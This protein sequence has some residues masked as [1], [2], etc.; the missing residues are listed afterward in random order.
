MDITETRGLVI[1]AGEAK[2]CCIHCKKALGSATMGI[3]A[4]PTILESR[5]MSHTILPVFFNILMAGQTEIRFLLH[6]QFLFTGTMSHMTDAAIP[7]LNRGMNMLSR[8]NN[9]GYILM[10]GEAGLTLGLTQNK[11]IIASMGIM[12]G[13]TL[14]LHKGLMTMVLGL[15][16]ANCLMAGQAKL[17]LGG[18]RL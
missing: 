14:A 11:G 9:L 1:V 16:F 7:S 17:T 15:L 12:T 5:G 6:Q 8:L 3:V 18:G 10:A 13:L 2:F 4:K